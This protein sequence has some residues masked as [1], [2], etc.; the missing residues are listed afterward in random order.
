ML[1]STINTKKYSSD[2][3]GKKRSMSNIM[4]TY[5]DAVY[6]E[7]ENNLEK[8]YLNFFSINSSRRF[9]SNCQNNIQHK[10]NSVQTKSVLREMKMFSIFHV[11][12]I[13]HAIPS[14]IYIFLHSFIKV[15]YF[16]S[17]RLTS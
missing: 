3:I 2:I 8:T 7:L 14:S 1:T 15:P 6:H 13:S 11:P 10:I 5:Y 17:I 4:D 16:N 9:S 12:V